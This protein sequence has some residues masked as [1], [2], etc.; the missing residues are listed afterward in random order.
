MWTL[1]TGS[2]V[3]L[4]PFWQMCSLGLLQGVTE[5]L[6]V[7][8]SAHTTALSY[9]MRW[10]APGLALNAVLHLGTAFSLGFYFRHTLAEMGNAWGRLLTEK[11]NRRDPSLIASGQLLLS[12]LPA[13][14]A[15]WLLEKPL[16]VY[17][18]QPTSVIPGL[19][20][21]AGMLWQAAQQPIQNQDLTWKSAWWL[22]CSQALALIPGISRSGVTL[23][24]ARYAGLAPATAL[25]FSFLSGLPIMVASGLFQLRHVFSP[26][27]LPWPYLWGGVC[28]AALSGWYSLHWIH[29]H[30][31]AQHLKGLALYR[32]G[33]ASYLSY[34]LWNRRFH[35]V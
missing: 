35:H 19:V 6:P 23:S 11:F 33:L 2:K 25:Q 20:I 16:S 30:F 1:W 8:S 3:M 12:T 29:H 9:L 4:R 15:G 7:S 14:L 10:P 18:R 28:S 26:P 27:R 17:T 31:S 13:G 21:G 5:Y 34:A 22:G 32:L 24:A